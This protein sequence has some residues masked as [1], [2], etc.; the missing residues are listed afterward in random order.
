MPEQLDDLTVTY[1]VKELLAEIRDSVTRTETKLDEKASRADLAHVA[2]RV[3]EI[4]QANQRR[5]GDVERGLEAIKNR[6]IGASAIV[7]LAGSVAG[8]VLAMLNR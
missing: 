1:G 8:Y 5:L 7:A 6:A 4:E 2:D 3:S